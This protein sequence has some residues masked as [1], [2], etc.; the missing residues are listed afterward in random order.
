MGG[1][2]RPTSLPPSPSGPPASGRW[3]KRSL[4]KL[5]SQQQ[6]YT[7][8][9]SSVATHSCLEEQFPIRSSGEGQTLWGGPAKPLP[10]ENP[11]GNQ[12]GGGGRA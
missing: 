11:T 12:A 10:T 6:K 1:Q 2:G 8:G 9:F 7:W 5:P 4:Q 3:V